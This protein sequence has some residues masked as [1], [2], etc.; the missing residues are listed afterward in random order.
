MQPN[1]D[2]VVSE[3]EFTTCLALRLLVVDRL[4]SVL[5]FSLHAK[6]GYRNAKAQKAMEVLLRC[7]LRGHVFL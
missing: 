2:V 4:D 3:P 5:P 7:W 6:N 1:I